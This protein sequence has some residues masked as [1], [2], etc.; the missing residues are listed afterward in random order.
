[1]KKLLKLLNSFCAYGL[2]LLVVF[3][4]IL[5]ISVWAHCPGG[6]HGI[7][8][9]GVPSD[10]TIPSNPQFPEEPCPASWTDVA[11]HKGVVAVNHP[12][13]AEVGARIL[14]DGG[15]AVDAAAAIQFALNV[16][17]PNFSGIGG[18]GFMMVHLAGEKRRHIGETFFLDIREKAPAAATPTM[19][20]GVPS[21]TNNGIAVGV[22][23]TLMG[24]ATALNLWGTISLSDAL[25]PAIKL[26]ED[27]FRVTRVLA[28]DTGD[29]KTLNQPETKAVFRRANGARLERGDLLVQP[30]LA[31]TFKLIALHGPDIFYRG[32]IAAAIVEA[33]KKTLSGAPAS[34]MGRMTLADL[35]LYDVKL[36]EPIVANYR[37]YTV[38]GA[39]PP[40][41]GG[42]TVIQMLKML[43]RFPLGDVSQG[44][45][46]GTTKTLH[47][48]IEAMRLAFADRAVWMGDEDFVAVP[49]VGLLADDY[50][51]LRS[52]LIQ[53]NSRMATPS[54]GDP[55]PFNSA[56]GT[57]N[58]MLAG[59]SLPQ[60]ENQ[61]GHTTHFSVVDKWNNIVTYTTTIEA[62]W[63]TGIMVPGYGFLLNNE[64]TDFN[65]TPTY[66]PA[67]GNPG[68]NDVAPFKRPRS[69]M[70]PTIL[71][72]DGK[73][74]AAFGS[75]GGATIINSVFQIIL[76]LIDHDMTIQE[77]IN[78]PR[79]S[80][81]SATGGL[82]RE[83][84]F[85]YEAV[86]GLTD[87]GHSVPSPSTIGAVQAVIID[88]R[89]GK[90]YGGAD[91][92]RQG[93]V[94][95]LTPPHS[96]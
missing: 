79:I 90:Q 29:S 65:L 85:S 42:L 40:S 83:E 78:A 93:T 55:W 34:A 60:E 71:L 67:T 77:A 52:N 70:A 37:G 74:F 14:E 19:F 28:S 95:G 87:L 91:S 39:P 16:V 3:G 23:G 73:P 25:Q 88:L 59:L 61:G 50:V 53:E 46:F 64:L 66:N 17:E 12:L 63:G 75:P 57:K 22:P 96:H 1:M 6:G 69:S 76:N 2:L 45:G 32:E 7:E 56:S 43:E 4:M 35:D 82:T 24:V 44:F 11:F 54:A 47:V 51:Q 18:G 31:K 36:R 94:I 49:K 72:K 9:P 33:Q 38:V 20:A 30:D 92:R 58:L 68:A 26:A 84:G 21:P 89:T 27:G 62:G 48:M 86:K 5:P 10:T 13:A 15:N 41:S 8:T 80:V 81:T